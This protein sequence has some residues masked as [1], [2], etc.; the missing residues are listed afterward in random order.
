[1]EVLPT[2]AHS[3]REPSVVHEDKQNAFV[4]MVRAPQLHESGEVRSVRVRVGVGPKRTP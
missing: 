3:F 2:A 1:M 4:A